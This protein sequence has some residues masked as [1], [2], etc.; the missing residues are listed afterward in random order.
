MGTGRVLNGRTIKRSGDTVCGL[1]RAQG[2]KERGFVGLASKPRSTGF[3]VWSSKLTTAVWF[4]P[5][6][7]VGYGLS[8]VPQNRWENEG[9]TQ[10]THRDLAACFAWK[11]VRLGFPSSAS[12]L[13]KE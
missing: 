1:H 11:Q 6:N 5:Q 8:V 12:K 13:M 9:S 7:Q 2:D 3:P 10:D 4:G